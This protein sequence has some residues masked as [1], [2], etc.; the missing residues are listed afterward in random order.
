MLLY[1]QIDSTNDKPLRPETRIAVKRALGDAVLTLSARV[2]M[3]YLLMDHPQAVKRAQC[4]PLYVTAAALGLCSRT[5]QRAYDE[6][7]R[8]GWLDD[9]R[10]GPDDLPEAGDEPERHRLL[11][12]PPGGLP[13]RRAAPPSLPPPTLSQQ[14]EGYEVLRE[15]ALALNKVGIALRAHS[16]LGRTM[17]YD[18][19]KRASRRE[20]RPEATTTVGSGWQE[21]APAGA[22]PAPA[23]TEAAETGSNWHELAGLGTPG[24]PPAAADSGYFFKPVSDLAWKDPIARAPEIARADAEWEDYCRTRNAERRRMGLEADMPVGDA[25]LEL[26]VVSEPDKFS[27]LD[28]HSPAAAAPGPI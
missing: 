8:A 28:R 26:P 22:A 18:R 3:A 5:V 21:P 6:L 27:T 14:I 17:G 23:G 20:A 15:R 25:A 7:E 11:H 9:S 12:Q 2:V 10:A 24:S 16:E 19:P 1:D 4:P 13:A